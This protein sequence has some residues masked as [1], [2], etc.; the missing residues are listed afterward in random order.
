MF[1]RVLFNQGL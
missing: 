1:C